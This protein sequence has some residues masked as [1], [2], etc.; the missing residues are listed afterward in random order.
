[1]YL[2]CIVKD[3]GELNLWYLFVMKVGILIRNDIININYFYFFYFMEGVLEVFIIRNFNCEV[4]VCKFWN[5][6]LCGD[7]V[8]IVKIF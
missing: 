2:L 7:C 1:M 3:D 8:Y 6:F 4:C 5:V